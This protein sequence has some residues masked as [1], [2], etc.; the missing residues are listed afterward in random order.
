MLETEFHGRQASEK[1]TIGP[2]WWKEERS[3]VEKR[4]GDQS[5]GK[6]KKATKTMDLGER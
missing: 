2:I 3:K 5:K 4:R 1:A 6:T